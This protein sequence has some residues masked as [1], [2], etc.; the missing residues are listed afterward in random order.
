RLFSLLVRSTLIKQRRA[1]SATGYESIGDQG[2]YKDVVATSTNNLSLPEREQAKSTSVD[3][4]GPIATSVAKDSTNVISTTA[5]GYKSTGNIDDISESSQSEDDDGQGPWTVVQPQRARSLENLK[6]IKLRKGIIKPTDLSQ[7]QVNMIKEA[8]K[9]LT[10]AQ[11]ESIRKRAEKV[12]QSAPNEFASPIAGPSYV[13][14]GKFT[15]NNE[16]VSDEELDIEAQ[17]AALTIW[18]EVCDAKVKASE[19]KDEPS[20]D[21][22]SQKSS[23]RHGR[24]NGSHKSE[25]NSSSSEEEVHKAPK[26]NRAKAKTSKKATEDTVKPVS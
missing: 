26:R 12:K 8:E 15:D 5:E 25:E 10:P 7:E 9:T 6:T 3:K 1:E 17:R 11:K 22:S 21:G 4:N 24:V 20:A 13:A 19:P 23:R 14:K 16:D 18:N 2:S